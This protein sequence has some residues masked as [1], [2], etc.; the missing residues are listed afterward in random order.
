MKKTKAEKTAFKIFPE[1]VWHP[2]IGM[3]NPYYKERQG[4]LLC[5]EQLKAKTVDL[6]LDA[7]ASYNKA[8][9]D[10]HDSDESYYDKIYHE[11]KKLA[12][13]RVL[14]D[15]M[16]KSELKELMKSNGK[17]KNVIK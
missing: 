11:G 6:Y 5:W 2:N 7:C 13:L 16:S 14:E 15:L 3:V 9:Q 17:H 4:F 10:A 8:L 1:Q 12:Y